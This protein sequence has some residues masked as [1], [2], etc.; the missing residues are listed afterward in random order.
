M[1]IVLVQVRP[2]RT[3]F[4]LRTPMCLFFLFRS[5]EVCFVLFS[6]CHVSPS[7]SVEFCP[8]ASSDEYTA[9]GSSV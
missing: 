4:F 5:C 7:C 9:I 6:T 8:L 2:S 3:G 1:E